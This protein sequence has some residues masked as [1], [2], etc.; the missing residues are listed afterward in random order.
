MVPF[1]LPENVQADVTI[2]RLPATLVLKCDI[3][4]L[5]GDVDGRNIGRWLCAFGG[6]HGDGNDRGRHP[7]QISFSG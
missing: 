1:R 2:T 7:S 6:Y 4:V 3:F 5:K